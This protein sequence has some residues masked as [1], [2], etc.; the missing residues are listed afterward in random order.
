MRQIKVL[1]RPL[2][3][4]KDARRHSA[5]LPPGAFDTILPI[6]AWRKPF[7]T[8]SRLQDVRYQMPQT[9]NGRWLRF[10]IFWIMSDPKHR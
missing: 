8:S 4:Q 3:V 6:G 2:R 1:Q 9:T 5:G 10:S 7:A